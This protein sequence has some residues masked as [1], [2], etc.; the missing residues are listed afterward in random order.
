MHSVINIMCIS[1]ILS[2]LFQLQEAKIR[3]DGRRKLEAAKDELSQKQSREM[4]E[5]KTEFEKQKKDNH[6]SQEEQEKALKKV[7]GRL[8]V[9][10]KIC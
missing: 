3:E 8:S 5:M 7:H 4:N 6:K 1:Y 9:V 2:C 10:L